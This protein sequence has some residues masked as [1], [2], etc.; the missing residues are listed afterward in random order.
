MQAN[1]HRYDD[2]DSSTVRGCINVDELI[3]Q[4]AMLANGQSGSGVGTGSNASA[5][6][7]AAA[8]NLFQSEPTIRQCIQPAIERAVRELIS[9]L[10][11]RCAHVTIPTAESI[12][13][14]DFTQ[15]ADPVPMM[16]AAR[17]MIRHLAASMS[18][19]TAR[20]AL[21][22]SLAN[23]MN[24]LIWNSKTP[25]QQEKE[26]VEFIVMLV[27]SRSMHACLAYMQKT[28]AEKVMRDLE[29][30]LE[31]DVKIRQE[32]GPR[33]YM[34]QVMMSQQNLPECVKQNV[35]FAT[36]THYLFK[37]NQRLTFFAYPSSHRGTSLVPFQRRSTMS[38]SGPSRALCPCPAHL[39]FLNPPVPVV[40]FR[41]PHLPPSSSNSKN[42]M[43]PQPRN[44]G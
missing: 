23:N 20:D 4:I 2:V 26:A 29:K 38:S 36:P 15:Q 43:L 12:I 32:L 21:S 42:R 25:T 1:L 40:P 30:K 16:R 7:A 27:V 17:Q 9:P 13:R 37:T 10:Y 24:S 33:R 6:A 28:V 19:V 11:E 3:Q 34:E 8:M 18:L 44:R 22:V 31:A 35:S 14:K 39:V 41:P 5:S